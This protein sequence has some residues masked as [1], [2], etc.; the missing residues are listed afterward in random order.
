VPVVHV[1][2]PSYSGGSWFEASPGKLF[3]RSYLEKPFTKKRTDGVA[4]GVGPEFKP[5]C[6]KKKKAKKLLELIHKFS[7]ATECQS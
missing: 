1:Y 2:N 3:V 5:Q 4:T 6:R 7:E